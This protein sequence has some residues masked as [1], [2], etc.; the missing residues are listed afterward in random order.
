MINGEDPRAA[1]VILDGSSIWTVTEDTYVGILL[2]T[3]TSFSNMVS[4]GFTVYYDSSLE[5]N[6]W[7]DGKSYALSGGG[8]L[9]PII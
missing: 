2:N 3:D 4:N 9:V 8:Y 5:G 1:T 6:A 7:L